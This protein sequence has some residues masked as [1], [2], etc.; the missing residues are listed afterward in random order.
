MSQFPISIPY[1]GVIFG[2]FS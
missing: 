2:R 1:K